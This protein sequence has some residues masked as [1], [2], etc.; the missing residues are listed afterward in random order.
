MGDFMARIVRDSSLQ[1]REARSRLKP[2]GKPYWRGIEQ[3]L[4]VGYRKPRKGP[5]R[6]L[7]RRY[8]GNQDY[9]F[10]PLGTADD[11]A[12]AD[13]VVVLSFK[14][15]QEHAQQLARGNAGNVG[16][17]R[18]AVTVAVALDHYEADLRARGAEVA[19][20]TRV[21]LHLG[22]TLAERPVALLTSKSLMSWRNGLLSSMTRS[23]A[24]R[25]CRAFKAALNLVADQSDGAQ[26][27]SAWELGLKSFDG[28]TAERHRN[29]VI[30][31]EHVLR[32]VAAAAQ[33]SEEF[34][35]FVETIAT[36][37]ARPSQLSRARVR[38]L[39]RDHLEMPSSR[40]GRREKQL[41]HRRVPIALSL[42]KRLRQAA[43]AAGKGDDALLFTRPDGQR[44]KRTDHSR[45]FARTVVRAG[46]DPAV[47]TLY[48]LRHSS[49]TRQL[50]AG[51]PIRVVAA[52]HDTST[53]MVEKTYSVEIDKHVDSIVRP[54]LL[55]T[56]APLPSN[57]A[58]IRARP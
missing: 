40:K 46:L 50:V 9:E 25:V 12:D 27:R 56:E 23:S 2:R 35:L 21:R 16:E 39:G 7:A 18:R 38:D 29:V 36:T 10:I 24:T 31:D 3:G 1:T 32:I 49:I 51:V 45:P 58:P 55:N 15:A 47:V 13:G 4:H 53:L 6:W 54:A 14:Q 8:K 37:G 41:S 22:K 30:P 28:A 11:F 26:G 5:G 33:Q 43:A 52:L 20:A 34:G 48:A 42:A 17:D 57:V 44:W 19:N